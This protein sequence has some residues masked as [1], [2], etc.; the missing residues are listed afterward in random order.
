MT[1]VCVKICVF[2]P[3]KTET[4]NLH[5]G[6]NR[7]EDILTDIFKNVL[8]GINIKL[9]LYHISRSR[10]RRWC[11]DSSTYISRN[12]CIGINIKILFITYVGVKICVFRP[13]KTQTI[14]LRL[15]GYQWDDSTKSLNDARLITLRLFIRIL[16][17]SCVCLHNDCWDLK[18]I[19]F[20]NICYFGN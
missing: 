4:T 16:Y 11:E 3:K 17:C 5:R 2:R 1:Y 13:K 14:N 10:S 19:K 6:N 9:L 20:V 15:C 18:Q 7:C 8:I 12:V